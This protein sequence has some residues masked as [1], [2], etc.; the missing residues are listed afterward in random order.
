MKLEFR[1]ID[2]SC[3][4]YDVVFCEQF[5]VRDFLQH[6]LSERKNDNGEIRLNEI[7]RRSSKNLLCEYS[8][9]EILNLK[10]QQFDE[11]ADKI[12]KR[13]CAHG[14][15]WSNDYTLFTD[16]DE[17][18]LLREQIDKLEHE[19]SYANERIRSLTD[20]IKEKDDEIN[21]LK[22]DKIFLD[23]QIAGMKNA[24][25]RQRVRGWKE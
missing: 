16:D 21:L 15:Y 20:I 7:S 13:I 19:L 25:P 17:I 18:I 1:S 23:Q 24:I 4:Y 2:N 11:Q 10:Q 22:K 3:D 8:C 14:G 5:T 6:I 12:V 9:G